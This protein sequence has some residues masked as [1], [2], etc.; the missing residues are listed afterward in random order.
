MLLCCLLFYGCL[1]ILA[2]Y[3]QSTCKLLLARLFVAYA[4]FC[5]VCFIFHQILH[6]VQRF[7]QRFGKAS[8]ACILA[9]IKCRYTKCNIIGMWIVWA[10][11][12]TWRHCAITHK[13]VRF[14]SHLLIIWKY[15]EF[16]FIANSRLLKIHIYIYIHILRVYICISVYINIFY[17]YMNIYSIYAFINICI[18]R[19]VQNLYVVIKNLHCLITISI[20]QLHNR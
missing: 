11:I 18:E 10:A 12:A 5:L 1:G 16:V 8:G 13:S 4:S 6:H 20:L 2:V 19:H 17:E 14:C 3:Q 9:G 15:G 7:L